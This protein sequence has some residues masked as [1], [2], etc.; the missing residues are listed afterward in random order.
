M[1]RIKYA[2]GQ[3]PKRNEHKGFT[4]QP[5]RYGQSIL[6]S[7]KNDRWRNTRQT[8]RKYN[9]MT[10][11]TNWRNLSQGTKTNW[12]TFAAT[13]P[14]PCK[15]PGSGNL[16]GYQLFIKRQQ[17]LF[18]NYGI[19]G[20]YMEAPFSEVL[21]LDPYTVTIDQTEN[22]LDVTELYIK[23]FGI[24]PQVG[25]Y[26]LLKVLPYAINS[27][28]F[29]PII[30]QTVEILESFLDGLFV[31]LHLPANIKDIV[32]SVYLS[33]QVHESVVYSGT[34]TRYMG[35]FTTKTF[36]GLTDTPNSYVNQAGKKVVVREDEKGLEFVENSGGGLT[37]ADLPDCPTIIGIVEQI[38]DLEE[39][40]QQVAENAITCADLPACPTIIAINANISNIID[41]LLATTANA[42]PAIKNGF[43]YNFFT[44]ID[45]RNIAPAGFRVATEADWNT[46]IT[47][48]GGTSSAGGHMKLNDLLY[49]LSISPGND[50]SSKLSL[51]GS[52]YRFSDGSF[53][54]RKNVGLYWTS[55]EASS[56]N[57]Y[58]KYFG[59][60]VNTAVTYQFAKIIGGAI[61]LIA[62]SGNPTKCIGNDG[63][64]YGTIQIGTQT[65]INQNLA[66]TKFST[67]EYIDGYSLAGYQHIYN[68]AWRNLT[69]AALCAFAGD[70]S[71]V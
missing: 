45:P 64:I 43:L 35:C 23:S 46:L 42:I 71:V 38:S 18:L 3:A 51:K 49:W 48:L 65:W 70:I 62:T 26:V 41:A 59:Y 61:R 17:Y 32:F 21:T 5:N 27:G 66:E 56:V 29:F 16:S 14:Q 44:A 57:A 54:D 37:C 22:C 69:K 55:T 53:Y 30:T 24:I 28:Q 33:K 1:A 2:E 50:N 58:C 7:Q 60:S 40:V 52:G 68:T 19:S 8:N 4:F 13:Y 10:A 67:G 47:Y 9:L 34:K 6:S 36:L 20:E 11:V 63:R 31:S 15:F 25:N 39:D 12:A